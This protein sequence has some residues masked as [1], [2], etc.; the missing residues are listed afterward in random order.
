MDLGLVD[1]SF[2][3]L[4][5][6]G[7]LLVLATVIA[8]AGIGD[9]VFDLRKTGRQR[10]YRDSVAIALALV[11]VILSVLLYGL[12]TLKQEQL[13]PGQQAVSSSVDIQ[14]QQVSVLQSRS[15]E[16]HQQVAQAATEF[17]TASLAA[18]KELNGAGSTGIPGKAIEY[19]RLV[20]V[21][22]TLELR[23][24]QLQAQSNQAD[25]A[26]AKAQATL[27]RSQLEQV[28]ALASVDKH[29][30]DEFRGAEASVWMFLF[31]LAAGLNCV[32]ADSR[33]RTH[34]PQVEQGEEDLEP[35][36]AGS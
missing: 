13:T 31:S 7:E 32:L 16:L 22:K 5:G 28:S 10:V 8:A 30:Y 20:A 35:A 23:L 18:Q 25:A 11:C 3:H 29:P 24:N 9:L 12:V 36:V 6:D 33:R 27:T 1:L 26:L 21:A 14:S 17:S 19:K 15:K 4:Y 2:D 34:Q